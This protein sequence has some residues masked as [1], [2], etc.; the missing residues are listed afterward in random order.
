MEG[1]NV[2][3]RR[4][5]RKKGLRKGEKERRKEGRNSFAIARDAITRPFSVYN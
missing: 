5:G 4:E 2:E 1:R 3:E